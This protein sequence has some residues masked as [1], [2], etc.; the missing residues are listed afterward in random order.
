MSRRL[1]PIRSEA[2][3]D[4]ALAEIT[5]YFEHEPAPGSAE[6]DRFDVLAALIKAYEDEH[7]PIEAPHSARRNSVRDGD[8]RLY[9][10]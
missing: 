6:A 2:D 1:Q 8:A 10:D 5:T 4:A 3:Y 9:P 7:W